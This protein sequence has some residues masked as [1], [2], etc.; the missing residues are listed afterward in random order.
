MLLCRR[1]VAD[2]NFERCCASGLTS[3]VKLSQWLVLLMEVA[4]APIYILDTSGH[5]VPVY[6]KIIEAS[7]L[8]IGIVVKYLCPRAQCAMFWTDS[9]WPV[10]STVPKALHSVFH[11]RKALDFSILQCQLYCIKLSCLLPSFAS[12]TTYFTHRHST[13]TH[14]WQI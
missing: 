3:F 6:L 9:I 5:S 12:D 13:Q 1:C 14:L 7:N 2:W 10:G 8:D 11:N 4:Q